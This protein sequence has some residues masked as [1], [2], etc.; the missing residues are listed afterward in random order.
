M[1]TAPAHSQRA[2]PL[3]AAGWRSWRARTAE[4]AELAEGGETELLVLKKLL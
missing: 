4:R 1:F 3:A 2:G